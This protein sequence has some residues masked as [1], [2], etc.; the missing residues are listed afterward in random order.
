MFFVLLQGLNTLPKDR[1]VFLIYNFFRTIFCHLDT[2][3][4]LNRVATDPRVQA[5]ANILMHKCEY[6]DEVNPIKLRHLSGRNDCICDV[7][8]LF[9]KAVNEGQLP[10]QV[11]PRIAVIGLFGLVDGLIYNWLMDDGYFPLVEYGEAAINT[12]MNGLKA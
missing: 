8:A 6:I 3:E 4:F 12:Y 9:E 1:L 7:E 5:L 11:S 10:P 2:N